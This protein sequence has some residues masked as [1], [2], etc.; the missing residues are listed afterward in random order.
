[1]CNYGEKILYVKGPC[2][3]L[4]NNNEEYLKDEKEEDNEENSVQIEE[5]IGNEN[6]MHFRRKKIQ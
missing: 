6:E 2:E 1:M 4:H 5:E 3:I